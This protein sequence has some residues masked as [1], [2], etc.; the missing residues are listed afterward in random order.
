MCLLAVGTMGTVMG[1]KGLRHRGMSAAV[2]VLGLAGGWSRIGI[3]FCGA[4]RGRA[5]RGSEG[6]FVAAS[7]AVFGRVVQGK[8]K[9]TNN[10]SSGIGHP[11][12]IYP[13]F[14]FLIF[15]LLFASAKQLLYDSSEATYFRLRAQNRSSSLSCA[16]LPLHV[17]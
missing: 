3:R 14:C 15:F 8:G 7:R 5:L 10:S 2:P 16:R 17:P 4:V 11:D 12:A 13:R 9:A 1:R 6:D